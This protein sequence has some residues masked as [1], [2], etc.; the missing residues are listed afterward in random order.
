MSP[1][2]R[3]WTNTSTNAHTHVGWEKKTSCT[4]RSQLSTMLLFSGTS[5]PSWQTPNYSDIDPSK[6]RVRFFTLLNATTRANTVS[7]TSALT[8]FRISTQ[9]FSQRN[10]FYTCILFS[11]GR[12]QLFILCKIQAWRIV[13]V[14]IV[15][16]YRYNV[17]IR[18]L[19]DSTHGTVY[20]SCSPLYI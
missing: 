16:I 20:G 2:N 7:P 4:N 12:K 19:V 11:I 3:W 14:M 9:C 17:S 15:A 6:R 5:R 13:A 18:F 8:L 10:C 1:F